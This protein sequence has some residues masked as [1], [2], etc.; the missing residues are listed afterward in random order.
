IRIRTGGRITSRVRPVGCSADREVHD[1]A[2]VGRRTVRRHCRARH[3]RRLG[4]R[5]SGLRGSPPDDR[6]GA[7][8]RFVPPRPPPLPPP[9]ATQAVLLVPDLVAAASDPNAALTV[10]LPNDLAFRVLVHDLTGTWPATEEATFAAVAGLGIDT[11]KAVLTYHIVGAE[12]SPL[13]LL[14]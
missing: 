14:R 13:T 9:L 11:V 5:R 1:E 10:F 6:P 7:A 2:Q 12:L 3:R 4:I 8:Q